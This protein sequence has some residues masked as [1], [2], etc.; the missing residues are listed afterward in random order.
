V[1]TKAEEEERPE[2]EE[3]LDPMSEQQQRMFQ[4]DI[5][6]IFIVYIVLCCVAA[7]SPPVLNLMGH[8]I[9]SGDSC[10]CSQYS[11]C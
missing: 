3:L 9:S 1:P 6:G 2:A 11:E 7:R 10:V 8:M 4:G 5:H